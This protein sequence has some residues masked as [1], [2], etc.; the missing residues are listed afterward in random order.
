M[1]RFFIVVAL[2]I[3]LAVGG[4]YGWFVLG[5]YLPSPDCDD[6]AVPFATEGTTYQV[7]DPAT[8][9]YRE[10]VVRGVDLLSSMPGAYATSYAPT[11]NDYLRW[12]ELIGAMGANTVRVVAVMDDDFYN[13]LY[14]YNTTH[15]A[16]L[17]LIQGLS[18]ADA[19]GNGA[20]DAYDESFLD[21]L[22]DTAKTAVDVVH[23]RRDLPPVGTQGSGIYRK[24]VSTWVAGYLVGTEWFSDTIAYTDHNTARPSSFAG[25]Y[26]STTADATAFEAM[27]AQVMDAMAS[28]ETN[29]YGVQ[30]PVGMLTAPDC[31]FL[32][33]KDVYARQ[34]Q[35]YAFVN[36]EHVV[37]TARM[38]A[39]RFAAYRLFDFCDNFSAYLEEEQAQELAPLLV[40]LDTTQIYG[41]YLQ[42]MARYHTMPLIAA[43]YHASSARSPIK[44]GVDPLSEQEQGEMLALIAQ[45]LEQDGW[46]GG[47]ISTWQ[48]AWERRS[49]NT[50]FATDPTN[51]YLWHDLQTD[52]Q[53]Y[54]LMAFSPGSEAVCVL[55]GDPDEWSEDDIVSARNGMTLSARFD[56]ECLY[57]LVTGVAPNEKAYIPIDVSEEVGS[58][59]SSEPSLTFDRGADFLLCLD[60]PSNTRLLVQERY[61]ALR[62]NFLYETEGDNPFTEFPALDSTAF[63]PVRTALSNPLLVDELNPETMALRRLGTWEAGLLVAGNGDPSSP[64]YNSLADICFGEQCVE[65]RLPWLLLNM[66]NPA[67]SQAHR[68]YYEH[69]GVEFQT[70]ETLWLGIARADENRTLRL[71]PFELEGWGA[72][73]PYRERLKASYAVM[74][75]LWGG[76]ETDAGRG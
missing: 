66:G 36:P 18:V 62:E 55:D 63:V 3:A 61:D 72:N 53:N 14:T 35:K 57:L 69:Y 37:P 51:S 11:E 49:W 34:L 56:A 75:Q 31:D 68:D 1:K 4:Y 20:N 71:K 13:A 10:L 22:I 30:R 5:L 24:D 60:G 70:T 59:A 74:Q 42:L 16:P 54:G 44:L 65:I 2:L 19:A 52:G 58:T 45:T 25:E 41:G 29:K 28:Y 12:L 6:P 27:L 23:G 32:I 43:G 50:A 73:L 64:E 26:F 47:C 9:R 48:D 21:T 15:A 46:A 38:E 76:G 33:Y 39:G 40:N 8:G 17:Y 7:L 67:S